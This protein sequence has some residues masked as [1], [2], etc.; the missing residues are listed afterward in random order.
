MP[1]LSAVLTRQRHALGLSL[2]FVVMTHCHATSTRADRPSTCR[3]PLCICM[4]RCNVC[5]GACHSLPLIRP[6]LAA[7]TGPGLSCGLDCWFLLPS[8]CYSHV[9]A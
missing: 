3:Q 7:L 9:L 5:W 4:F 6:A 8:L 1:G 2:L